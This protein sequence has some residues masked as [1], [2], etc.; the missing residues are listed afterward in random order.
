MREKIDMK[1][2]TS[3]LE[4]EIATHE[5]TLRQYYSNKDAILSDLD[6]WD[7]EGKHFFYNSTVKLLCL[8]DIINTGIFLWRCEMEGGYNADCYL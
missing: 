8:C 5:K 4:Q 7:Y 1:V 3:A 6:N 2:D